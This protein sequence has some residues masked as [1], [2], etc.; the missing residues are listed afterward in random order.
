MLLNKVLTL[1]V[2][3]KKVTQLKLKKKII[4]MTNGCFDIIHS[5]HIKILKKSKDLGDILIVAIN[6]DK[7]IKANKGNDRPFNTLR[8]RLSVLNSISYI[9]YV[10]VFNTETPDKLY[11]YILP[12]ILTKG[13]EY[14]RQKS[15]IAGGHHVMANKGKIIF[16]SMKKNLS[17]TNILKR[18]KKK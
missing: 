4:V 9:D 6:S 15:N 13:A 18:I 14:S 1:K 8:D 10:L 3:K 2:L 12:N 17:T 7:S 5:G 16:V 11:K